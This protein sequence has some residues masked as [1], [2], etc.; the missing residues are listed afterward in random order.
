MYVT[1]V[2]YVDN[3]PL[4]HGTKY[5]LVKMYLNKIAGHSLLYICYT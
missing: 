4:S 1:S 5:G 2:V 3:S